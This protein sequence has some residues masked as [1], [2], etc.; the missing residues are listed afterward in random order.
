MS[1]T[2]TQK[3]NVAQQDLSKA[4]AAQATTLKDMELPVEDFGKVLDIQY[5]I[6][7]GSIKEGDLKSQMLQL[8]KTDGAT[9]EKVKKILEGTVKAKNAEKEVTEEIAKEQ[10]KSA[11]SQA[12]A[13]AFAAVGLGIFGLLAK[14]ATSFAQRID[15]I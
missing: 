15:E 3:A 5:G 1:L 7:D 12:R 9:Q 2:R 6:V 8:S 14:L 11:K 10:E 13:N 4:V